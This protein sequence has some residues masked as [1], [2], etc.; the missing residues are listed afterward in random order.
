M[1]TTTR[2]VKTKHSAV[3]V[4]E[5]LNSSVSIIFPS[6]MNVGAVNTQS[7][8]SF[9]TPP[10]LVFL[11]ASFVLSVRLTISPA[12]SLSRPSI[13]ISKLPLHI[14]RSPGHLLPW[15]TGQ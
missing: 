1:Q 11:S 13:S 6:N 10:L 7:K 4:E 3:H 8:V 14:L 15:P 9:P 2:G 5:L 12:L